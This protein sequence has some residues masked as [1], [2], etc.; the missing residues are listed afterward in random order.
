MTRALAVSLWISGGL[1]A[2]LAA[3][4]PWSP[5][6]VRGLGLG[7][8][9]PEPAECTVRFVAMAERPRTPERERLPEMPP[10]LPADG[11][12]TPVP[13]E[14]FQEEGGTG[15][16]P[17]IDVPAAPDPAER[18]VPRPAAGGNL[19][20][21][22]PPLPERR[23][24]RLLIRVEDILWNRRVDARI[25]PVSQLPKDLQRLGLHGSVRLMLFLTP[26]GRIRDL[27]VLDP[28]PH[29]ALTLAAQAQVRASAPFPPAP[30]GMDP[31]W[32]RIP[33]NMH[34]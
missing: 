13:E 30:K 32:L 3:A 31:A 17:P 8:P 19:A 1:H 18:R 2:G 4:I 21:P 11:G 29:P 34:Y 12:E 27:R 10:P 16:L 5:M 6:A 23:A 26:D 25:G 7:A 24:S 20:M 14:P 28:G 22:L 15:I 33:V 9:P